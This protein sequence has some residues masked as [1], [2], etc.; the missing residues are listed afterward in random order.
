MPRAIDWAGKDGRLTAL[1]AKGL[2]F[3]EIG[4]VLGGLGE[5]TVRKRFERLQGK[6][7]KSRP[8]GWEPSSELIQIRRV[9]AD[10][11]GISDEKLISRCR[12]RQIAHARQVAALVVRTV[13]PNLS[14][15]CIARLM[16]LEDHST[17]IYGCRNAMDRIARD[18]DL[19][20]K[21][22]VLVAL[23][24]KRRD[25]RQHDSHVQQWR[26]Y[27]RVMIRE[28]A[29]REQ[30]EKEAEAARQEALVAG[31]LAEFRVPGKQ[32]CPQCDRA[33]TDGEARRCSQRL[34]ALQLADHKAM[35]A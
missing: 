21:F 12:V 34:C 2:T 16:G 24:G 3:A 22:A 15:P 19:A 14:Y 27:R 30:A 17:V 23:F 35:A 20:E 8:T 6:V 33:V 26:E 11:L 28:M 9:C 7:Q 18:P 32:F 31:D 1:R 10:H 5:E 4:A 13:R 29:A 25:V